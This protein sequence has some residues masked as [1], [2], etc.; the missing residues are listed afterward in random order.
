MKDFFSKHGIWILLVA[1]IVTVS[2]AALSAFGTGIATPL[3]NAAGVLTAPVR[4]CMTTASNWLD[5]RFRYAD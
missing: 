3:K 2:L 1:V 5:D 4:A